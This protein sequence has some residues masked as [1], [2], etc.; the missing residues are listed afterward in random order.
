MKKVLVAEDE[1]S[2]REFIVL[3]L[4]MN[5]YEVVE[6]SDGKEAIEL[7]DRYFEDIDI[8][9]LDIMMPELSGDEVCSH[10]RRKSSFVGIIM[11]TAKSQESDKLLSFSYG[12]DDYVTKP[13][14][15]SELVARVDALY[16][17]ISLIRSS[18]NKQSTDQ[19]VLGE[20]E[21]NHRKRT[22]KKNGKFIELTQVEYQIIE[23]LFQ[24][25]DNIVSRK[26]ILTA[27]WGEDF[28]GGEKIVDVNIRRIRMKLESEP[29]NPKNLLTVWGQG[30][31]WVS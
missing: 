20:F 16:R 10:V 6:A 21:L 22:L 25:C 4:K 29:S 14:S 17:K 8:C 30:Y 1:E 31:K 12:A 11:L 19:T 18:I 15:P 24:N 5:G 3:N 23:L 9:V 7:Y 27:V 26:S 13:F 28:I 2:I